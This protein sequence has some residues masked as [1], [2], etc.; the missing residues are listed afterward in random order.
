M[1]ERLAHA[2]I[3][4]RR[5]VFGLWLVLSLIGA[6]L[7]GGIGDRL[8]Q[9]FSIPGYSA[10]EA[11]Q[12]IFKDTHSGKNYTLVPVFHSNGDVTKA[13]GLQKRIAT[14]AAVNPGSRVSSYF[15]TGH[16]P[17]YVSKDRHTMFAEI[18][19]AGAVS[20]NGLKTIPKSRAALQQ[21]LPA[22]VTA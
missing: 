17:A 15:N 13:P 4:R 10:Y 9:Q 11:N 7:A 8:S 19:P 3:R 6:G 18:Y 1:M 21:G 14:A 16:S 5:I 2:V 12:R 20:F 22:G